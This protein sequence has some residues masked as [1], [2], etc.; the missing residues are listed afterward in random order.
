VTR[1]DLHLVQGCRPSAATDDLIS[2]PGF[3]LQLAA[4]EADLSGTD[5]AWVSHDE[6]ERR[7]EERRRTS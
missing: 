7:H 1:S 4:I 2:D 6:V 5:V 3:H